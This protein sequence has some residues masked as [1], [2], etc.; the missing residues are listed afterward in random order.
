[1]NRS[2]SRSI[3]VTTSWRPF[4]EVAESAERRVREPAGIAGEAF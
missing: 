4:I 1:M 2:T 3:A